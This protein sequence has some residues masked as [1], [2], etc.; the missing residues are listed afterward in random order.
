MQHLIGHNDTRDFNNRSEEK[1]SGF[2][3]FSC[4]KKYKQLL[5]LENFNI[6]CYVLFSISEM[7]IAGAQW[8]LKMK[9]KK[10][11]VETWHTGELGMLITTFK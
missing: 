1:N 6:R 10:I 9:G 3:V 11:A 4:K 2:R 8:T 5:T 7:K